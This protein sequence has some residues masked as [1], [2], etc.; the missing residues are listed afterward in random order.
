MAIG[1]CEVL[2]YD[3]RRDMADF[4]EDED[5]GENDEEEKDEGLDE[6]EGL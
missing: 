1:W 2:W 5:E 6:D 4:I 3:D